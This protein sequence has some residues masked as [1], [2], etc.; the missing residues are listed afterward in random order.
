MSLFHGWLPY[1]L[2]RSLRRLG[3][4]RRAF[5]IQAII[6]TL[7]LL[8]CYFL[9][10][11]PGTVGGSRRVANV[12]Y[13]YGTGKDRPQQRVSEGVWLAIVVGVAF[14]GMFL[15]AHLLLRRIMPPP[16]FARS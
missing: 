4:D 5:R 10:A 6:G 2:L 14:L 9:F 11:P 7:L 8:T 1:L 16:R 13:V 3:Y 12:N 15:P